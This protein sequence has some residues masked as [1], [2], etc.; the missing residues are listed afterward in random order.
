M[1]T[2]PFESTAV[3]DPANPQIYLGPANRY[4]ARYLTI[5][6]FGEINYLT[7]RPF[8]MSLVS[9]FS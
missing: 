3:M 1:D 9:R 5:I 8:V 4:Q 2:Q 7:K 6:Y